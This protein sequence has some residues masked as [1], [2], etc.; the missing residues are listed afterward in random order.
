MD[1]KLEEIARELDNMRDKR[2]SD[3]GPRVLVS[4]SFETLRHYSHR[5]RSKWLRFQSVWLAFGPR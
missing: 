4:L 1:A 2:G 5:R 3:K